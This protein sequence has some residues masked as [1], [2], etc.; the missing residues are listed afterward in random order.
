MLEVLVHLLVMQ[1]IAI[2]GIM[3]NSKQL[4]MQT[5]SLILVDHLDE[6][7]R[8]VADDARAVRVAGT[9]HFIAEENRLTMTEALL[10]FLSVET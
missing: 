7:P 9:G 5:P 8:E 3:G 1:A 10:S 4:R 2:V 6:A